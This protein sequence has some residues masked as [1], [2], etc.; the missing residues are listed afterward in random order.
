[1]PTKNPYANS[2]GSIKNG[3]QVQF[4]NWVKEQHEKK[5]SVLSKKERADLEK[6]MENMSKKM[7]S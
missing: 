6:A 3:M 2:D 4:W 1:M 7:N 5:I